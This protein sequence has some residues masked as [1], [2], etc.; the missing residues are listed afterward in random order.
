MSSICQINYLGPEGSYSHISAK[1]IAEIFI[2]KTCFNRKNDLITLFESLNNKN[3]IFKSENPKITFKIYV[4]V[5]VL[6]FFSF[7][8]FPTK[9]ET[10]SPA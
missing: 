3:L 6:L 5:S 10:P 2:N 8:A 1:K 9:S 4:I 7:G